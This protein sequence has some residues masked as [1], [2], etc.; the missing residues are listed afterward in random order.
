MDNKTERKY[1]INIALKKSYKI[2]KSSFCE[3]MKMNSLMMKQ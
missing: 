3:V 1:L 2:S